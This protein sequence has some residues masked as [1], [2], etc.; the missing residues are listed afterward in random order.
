M[1]WHREITRSQWRTLIAAQLGWMLDAMDVMLYSF[2]LVSIRGEFQLSSAAAG[3]R[4]LSASGRASVRDVVRTRLSH[5]CV[6]DARHR[7][8]HCGRHITN[9]GVLPRA[10]RGSGV[11]GTTGENPARASVRRRVAPRA[12]ILEVPVLRKRRQH[13][14]FPDRRGCVPSEDRRFAA[15]E[16]IVGRLPLGAR[17]DGA[18]W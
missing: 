2:A 7:S 16:G 9:L 18:V 5:L 12:A 6:A 1:Q 4:R 17:V 15:R 11:G 8:D 13:P 10:G 14:P 3:A